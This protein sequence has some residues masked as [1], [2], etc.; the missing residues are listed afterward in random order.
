MA[1]LKDSMNLIKNTGKH[2][3]VEK[4]FTMTIEN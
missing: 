2:L 3:A 1:I 4:Y